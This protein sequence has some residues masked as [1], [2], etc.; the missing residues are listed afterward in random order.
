MKQIQWASPCHQG[1]N[2]TELPQY[3][4]RA[5]VLHAN[6]CFNFGLKCTNTCKDVKNFF[7]SI[8]G[9]RFCCSPSPSD[10]FP[11]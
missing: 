2:K 8:K 7:V 6:N 3:I 11:K 10:F 4:P 5:E 1:S 9:I